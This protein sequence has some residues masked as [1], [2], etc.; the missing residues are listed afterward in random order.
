MLGTEEKVP[1]SPCHE[2]DG[3][4]ASHAH[5]HQR[6]RNTE[7]GICFLRRPHHPSAHR[8]G[9]ERAA[10][11][12]QDGDDAHRFGVRGCGVQRAHL[13]GVGRASRGEHGEGTHGGVSWHSHWEDPHTAR[14]GDDGSSAV[15]LQVAARHQREVCA[16]AGPHAGVGGIHLQSHQRPRRPRCGVGEDHLCE[17]GGGTRGPPAGVL[18]LPQNQ[19]RMRSHRRGSERDEVYRSRHW[20]LWRQV[21][22]HE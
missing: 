11:H 4:A 2:S 1:E 10:V 3:S 20:R 18:H 12:H 8:G 17:F 15:L 22:R 19:D 5:H 13:R 14:R 7:G 6:Q 16:A 9:P 21:F